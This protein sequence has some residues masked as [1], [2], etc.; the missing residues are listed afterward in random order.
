MEDEVGKYILIGAICAVA[1]VGIFQLLILLVITLGT[2]FIPV[3]LVAY[4]VG[5]LLISRHKTAQRAAIVDRERSVDLQNSIATYEDSLSYP[6][7]RNSYIDYDYSSCDFDISWDEVNDLDDDRAH[8]FGIGDLTCKYNA[9]S[10]LIRC[11]VNPD[12]ECEDCR[13][14]E[15]SS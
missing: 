5:K 12:V 3:Y 9:R 7:D 14:Y 15:R 13:H 6:S 2:F 8:S 1:I 11:A 4:M 10:P